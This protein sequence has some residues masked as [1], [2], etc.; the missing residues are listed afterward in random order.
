MAESCG[1]DDFR[2]WKVDVLRKYCQDR[3]LTASNFKRKDEL[4]ALAFTAYTQKLPLVVG[5]QQE[6][7]DAAGDYTDL[8]TLD[9]GL[10]IPDPF[11]LTT[12]WLSES[13]GLKFWPPCMML[14]ISEYLVANGER[15]LYTRL[16]NDY[17]EG[18]YHVGYYFLSGII[19]LNE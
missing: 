12:N 16:R 4:V 13:D 5:K 9:S 3:G 14:N 17:K 18:W 7:L 1:I 6:K 15:P 2:R 8:L 19:E 11:E 10:V